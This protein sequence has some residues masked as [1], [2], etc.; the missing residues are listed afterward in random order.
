[1]SSDSSA[2]TPPPSLRSSAA[3]TP[4]P[5]PLVRMARRSPFIGRARARVS[6]APKISS[7]SLT[8]SMPAR[9]SAASNTMSE[10]ARRPVCEMA[11]RAP[12]AERPALMASTGLL[13]AAARAPDMKPRLA[14]MVSM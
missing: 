11:A 4:M 2:S 5:P 12:S 14:S 8:R 6:T 9:R 13:R 10:P 3:I 7:M 1:M